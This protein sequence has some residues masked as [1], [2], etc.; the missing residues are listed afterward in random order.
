MRGCIERRKSFTLTEGNPAVVE[1][2]LLKLL[3]EPAYKCLLFVR[4]FVDLSATS[5][6]NGLIREDSSLAETFLLILA[7]NTKKCWAL[8]KR[9]LKYCLP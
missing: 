3:L 5:S 2:L 7:H 6:Q 4:G 8:L 1:T 9:F